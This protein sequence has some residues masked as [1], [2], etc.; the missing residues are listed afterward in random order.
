MLSAVSHAKGNGREAAIPKLMS[1]TGLQFPSRSSV[2][3]C[4]LAWTC[5]AAAAR[6]RQAKAAKTFI[7]IINFSLNELLS[8]SVQKFRGVR[9]VDP[10]D[11]RPWPEPTRIRGGRR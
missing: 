8:A 1:E 10:S 3:S 9:H 7:L 6:A 11:A 5:V 2:R 4:A